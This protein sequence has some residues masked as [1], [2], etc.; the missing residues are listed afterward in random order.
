M[1]SAHSYL[2]TNPEL[3][4]QNL[5]IYRKKM[6]YNKTNRHIMIYVLK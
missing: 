5:H 6:L 2:I 4:E 1:I 3:E